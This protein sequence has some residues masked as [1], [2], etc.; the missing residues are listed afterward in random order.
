MTPHSDPRPRLDP[1]NWS[2]LRKPLTLALTTAAVVAIAAGGVTA[3]TPTVANAATGSVLVSGPDLDSHVIFQ[4]FTFYQPYESDTYKTLTANASKLK[5]MGVTD[6]WMAPPYR[7]LNAYNEEG[8]AVTDRYDLGEF[9]AGHDGATA[10]KYG[11]AAELKTAIAALHA[12]GLSVQADIV[13]NQIY[14]YQDRE[15]RRVTA[16]DQWG[17]PNNSKVVNK[18]YEVYT[19]GGGAGAQKYGEIKTWKSSN[20]NGISNQELGT[21]RV[22][23]DANGKPY[24]YLGG[25]PTAGDNYVPTGMQSA[26]NINNIDG[27]LTV[28][29]YFIAGQTTGGA[30]IWRSNLLYYVESQQGATTST[31]LDYVRA[32]PPVGSGILADDSDREVRTKLIYA[33][34]DSAAVNTTNDYIGSQPGYNSTSEQGIT[35]LRFDD[36]DTSNVNKN[37]LQYEF[38]LGQD[39][40]NSDATVQAEQTNWEKFLYEEYDFDGFRWDAAGHYNTDILKNAAV[41]ASEN[42][43]ADGTSVNDSLNYL[44]SY[45]QEQVP[46][47]NA[48]GNA[49][50]AYD[51]QPYYAYKDALGYSS[52]QRY[53][54][55]TITSSFVD[56]TSG[57]SNTAIPNWSWVN[58]H[59]QEHN[60]AAL[61]PVTDE[62]TG[63]ASYGTRQFQQAQY[64]IYSADRKKATKQYAP[65]NV[66]ASY[67]IMLTNKDTVPS[68]FYGDMYES[69]D[70]YMK[71]KSPYYTAISDLMK[72]R[73]T[74]VSGPQVVSSYTS[75][76][77]KNA[78]ED[79]ISSVRE[80][81]DRETGIGVV[82]GND[83][84]LSTTIN[85]PM[86]SA[87]G[88][89][90]YV[91]AL[92]FHSETLTTDADGNLAVEVD[93]VR[94]VQVNG[95]LAA[96]VPKST[97]VETPDPT[98]PTD[99]P[100]DP[101]T[102]VIPEVP[103]GPADTTTRMLVS[104]PK[105]GYGDT[106]TLAATVDVG[107][108]G[109]IVF[110]DGS[111][112]IAKGAV[113]NGLVTATT[114]ASLTVRKHSITAHYSGDKDFA[115][116]VSSANN[117][118]IAKAPTNVSVKKITAVKGSKATI[119][120]K[121]LSSTTGKGVTGKVR[122]YAGGKVVKTVTLSAAKKG[123]ISVTLPKAYS[124]KFTV[125]ASYVGSKNAATKTSKSL[126][127]TPSKR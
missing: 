97:A 13:P 105:L 93:G 68:V 44:E 121:A 53:L 49:Q 111:K 115:A 54:S 99:P 95:Y 2:I 84:N 104:E 73:E 75:N 41:T 76:L 57:T 123:T 126:K 17:T 26:T 72:V 125:K 67:A 91:D 122:I 107:A 39:V 108:T 109:T 88:N 8:Y 32:H 77:T 21:D 7:A 18:L 25:D 45:V 79:L 102:P 3:A 12:E 52:P 14:L 65:Y 33:T 42:R 4:D 1:N 96:W 46:Y 70:S 60:V 118:T 23:L 69:T 5:E 78:G 94:N 62:Q 71:T 11:T 37:V 6:V 81:T 113:K 124:T 85:V 59:D 66:P 64:K 61:I 90:E 36:A 35:A 127:I 87:H 48:N 47:L 29:G 114:P 31:Y 89:Q 50:L 40:D 55:D 98:D 83:A 30:D 106:T 15:V 28:D 19:V 103:S 43:A 117:L 9:P 20:L 10:T 86:G 38:L 16:V 27:Y 82:V 56:R 24:R 119:Q 92:G 101:E 34:T 120:V 74:N 63:G 80:G 112:T 22:M 110:K 58:N 116:S 51:A 100:T